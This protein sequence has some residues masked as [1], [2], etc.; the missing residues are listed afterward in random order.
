MCGFLW[1]DLSS[2]ISVNSSSLAESDTLFQI[3]K[4]LSAEVE[5]LDTS[6]L[7]NYGSGK[8][9]TA[10]IER[11]V[12]KLLLQFRLGE[13]ITPRSRVLSTLG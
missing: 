8:P 9:T 6:K 1:E 10:G 3:R 11:F 4:S 2:C 5:L 12:F 13:T 7:C